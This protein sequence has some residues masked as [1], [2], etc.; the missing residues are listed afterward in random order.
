MKIISEFKNCS[1]KG[2]LFN[3]M[4]I[5]NHVNLIDFDFVELLALLRRFFVY[6]DPRG[7]EEPTPLAGELDE[8]TIN[9]L[10]LA[11]A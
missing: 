5:R 3:W 8:V 10:P 7:S 9:L 1:T 2:R 11:F 4:I 6:P